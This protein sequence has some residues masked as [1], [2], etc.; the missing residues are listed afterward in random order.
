M[1]IIKGNYGFL[2]FLF[3]L[4]YLLG[5]LP[6]MAQQPDVANRTSSNQQLRFAEYSFLRGDYQ[7]A[8][9]S[10][11]KYCKNKTC[12]N[13]PKMDYQIG[14]CMLHVRGYH[15]DALSF[16]EKASIEVPDRN[17]SFHLQEGVP[18][19]VF[20][21]L[22]KAY[23]IN[24]KTNE[25]IKAYRKY[26]DKLPQEA[27]QAGLYAK[28][29][30]E[31][32]K[33]LSKYTV[34]PLDIDTTWLQNVINDTL[35]NYYP[36][37]SGNGKVLIYKTCSKNNNAIY[38]TKKDMDGN[39]TEPE[40]INNQLQYHTNVYPSSLSYNGDMLFC[41]LDKQFDA[42]IY[43]SEFINGKWSPIKKLPAPINTKYWEAN[44]SI[45]SDGNTLYFSSNRKGSFGSLDIF[46]S[47]K[48]NEG[49]WQEPVNIGPTINTIFN[50]DV[51]YIS[52]DGK[53]LLFVSQGHKGLGGYDIFLT[54]L[55]DSGWCE[56]KNM[57][58]P[59]NTPDDDLFFS[60][61]HK[62]QSIYISNYREGK[63]EDICKLV[64]K[65]PL[66]KVPEIVAEK[67]KRGRKIQKSPKHKAQDD[68]RTA[69]KTTREKEYT[70]QLMALTYPVVIEHQFSNLN[71]VKEWYCNDKLFRY[72]IYETKKK[73]HAKELLEK[74]KQKGFTSFIANLNQIRDKVIEVPM[75]K[76][77]A[78][79]GSEFTIQIYASMR[80]IRNYKQ[81]FNDVENVQQF[82]NNNNLYVYTCGRFKYIEKA[83]LHLEKVIK[84]GYSDAFITSI[85]SF[86]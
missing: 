60:P 73:Q 86:R 4:F 36:V 61:Q 25:A 12:T 75:D 8:L 83:R 42:D 14:V 11:E 10:Y 82:Q 62:D 47:E 53:S 35:R 28:K 9:S 57:G 27:K 44:A 20:F 46:M 24:Y 69:A 56:P 26:L 45:T 7:D 78:P 18:E 23:Q 72:T 13:N 66:D 22:G 50:E 31:S 81:K 77:I 40:N 6:I 29:Q 17:N 48:D 34:N 68:I 70:I 37:I 33:N 39:W 52:F 30:I 16:L 1:G 3:I 85:S 5:L 19:E 58:Y 55:S 80:P 63:K 71:G 59:I 41:D 32:C 74:I 84:K 64:I 67:V 51:P 79:H 2:Q 76:G 15:K 21:Y 43:S 38:Y 54:K 49:A 65:E